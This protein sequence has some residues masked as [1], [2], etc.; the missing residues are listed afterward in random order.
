MRRRKHGIAGISRVI[1]S[2]QTTHK[3]FLHR[4]VLL[5]RR[6]VQRI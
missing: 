3:K 4:I 5:R 6:F 2:T 1:T